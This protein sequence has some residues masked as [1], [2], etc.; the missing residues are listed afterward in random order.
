MRT[1]GA[2][3]GRKSVR[4]EAKPVGPHAVETGVSVRPHMVCLGDA[5]IN[6]THPIYF[7][8][9]RGEAQIFLLGGH[10]MELDDL[11]AQFLEEV[12]GQYE[13]LFGAHDGGGS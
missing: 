11:E 8:A 7:H 6:L 13:D 2:A 10:E 4:P 9:V 1:N 5:W 3:N 12:L